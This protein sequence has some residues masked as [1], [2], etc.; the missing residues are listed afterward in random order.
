MYFIFQQY[1][2]QLIQYKFDSFGGFMLDKVLEENTAVFFDEKGGNYCLCLRA[3]Q[4]TIYVNTSWLFYLSPCQ[5]L[6]D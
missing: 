3:R 6:A 4:H 1:S 5:I 2:A